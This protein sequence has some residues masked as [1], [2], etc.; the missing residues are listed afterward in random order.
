LQILRREAISQRERRIDRRVGETTRRIGLDRLSNH[1]NLYLSIERATE[2]GSFCGWYVRG[3]SGLP[4]AGSPRRWRKK[5][6]LRCRRLLRGPPCTADPVSSR[7]RWSRRRSPTDQGQRPGELLL[8][9]SDSASAATSL[10]PVPDEINDRTAASVMMQGLTAS[11]FPTDFYPVQLGD[12]ALVHAAAGGLGLLLTQ[13]I[14]L[15]GGHVIGRV[16]APDTPSLDA[17]EWREEE[18][19][20]VLLV[21]RLHLLGRYLQVHGQDFVVFSQ[22]RR[23]EELVDDDGNLVEISLSLPVEIARQIPVE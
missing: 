19:A 11:H 2:V 3:F 17:L 15:R 13:I 22:I 5:D 10:E 1:V 4:K 9:A 8:V 6:R 21:T 23:Q 16:D 18:F 14:K 12:I 7:Y 20:A